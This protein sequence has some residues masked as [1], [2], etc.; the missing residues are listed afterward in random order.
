MKLSITVRRMRSEDARIHEGLAPHDVSKPIEYIEQCWKENEEEQ[1][2]T[3]IAWQG[4]E[5]AGW[6]HVVY[7]SNYPYFAENHIPEIQNLDVVPPV[8]KCGIGSV[9]ME[10]LEAEVFAKYDSAGIGFGLYDSYGTAQRLYVK[11]GYVPDGRGLMYDNQPVVP[12][13]QVRVDDELT[14]YL[15]KTRQR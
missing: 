14:L 15:V 11:R 9:L 3:L 8:R 12:G 2:L 10:A 4:S 1:R 5:F 13:S 6:G 7:T